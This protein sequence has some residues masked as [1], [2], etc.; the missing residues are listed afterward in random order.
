M[1]V[2]GMQSESN[3]KVALKMYVAEGEEALVKQEMKAAG[4][5]NISNYLRHCVELESQTR[6]EASD[7]EKATPLKFH[8]RHSGRFR[9]SPDKKRM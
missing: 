1:K 2:D 7:A 6:V 9:Q 5:S 8:P 3:H 4:Y